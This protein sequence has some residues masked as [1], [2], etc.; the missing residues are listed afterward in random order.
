MIHLTASDFYSY[1]KPDECG[2]RIHLKHKGVK[3]AKPSAYEEVLKRL[4]ER[5]ERNHLKSFPSYKDLSKG[6]TDDRVQ[7]TINA[8]KKQEPVIYQALFKANATLNGKDC[9]I[10]GNPDFLILEDGAYIIRDSKISRRTNEE[11]HPEIFRQLEIYGW[12]FEETFGQPPAKL[13]VHSGTDEIHDIPYD[14]GK[15]AL[16]ILEEILSLKTLASEPY[17][18]V[19]WSKC[20][21]CGFFDHCWPIAEKNQDPAIL[22]GVDKGLAIA[23]R[24]EG[25]NNINEFLEQFDEHS[26]EEFKR[27]WGTKT[28]KVGKTAKS[29]LLMAQ[30]LTSGE[31]ML[32][33]NPSIPDHQNYCM[34]DVEG[35]PPHLKEDEKIYLWGIQVFGDKPSEYKAALAGFG[36]NGD[37]EC[38]DDFLSKAKAIFD[39]HGDI[40]FVHWSSYEKSR[41]SSY[42]KRYGDSNGIADRIDKNLLDLYGIT[43]KSIVLPLPSYSLKIVEKYIKFER[44]LE[45]YGGDWAIAKYI[46]A[47]E[48]EDEEKRKE[49]MDEIV[50]YN[51]EDLEATWAVLTW[52]KQKKS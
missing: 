27:P 8:V 12:L 46:E 25:I 6:A 52:L 48:T 7:E 41:L 49:V 30:S 22:S 32:L 35:L 44:K 5:H 18:P 36:S 2:L 51:K 40:P 3:E 37:Q 20:S 31:E 33:Q 15:T 24:K 42:M 50:A 38:W 43:R 1:Y 11:D 28:Q 17:S 47:V 10:L 16:Q 45:E 34:F 29:I 4:G 14:K 39:E 13:Q 23:L 9:A 19:G 26:L 21:G